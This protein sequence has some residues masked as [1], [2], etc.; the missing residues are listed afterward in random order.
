MFRVFRLV[1]VCCRSGFLFAST[2]GGS[3]GSSSCGGHRLFIVSIFVDKICPNVDFICIYADIF[4]T[5][6]YKIN[7]ISMDS[8]SI[9]SHLVSGTMYLVGNDGSVSSFAFSF[10][11][12]SYAQSEC[13]QWLFQRPDLCFVSVVVGRVLVARAGSFPFSDS[14]VSLAPLGC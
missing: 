8:L 10:E 14:S 9:F 3:A 13:R 6:Q 2:F 11:S 1:V 5:L 4:V 12:R 7:V